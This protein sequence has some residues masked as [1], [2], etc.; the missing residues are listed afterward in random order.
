MRNTFDQCGSTKV[1]S[2]LWDHGKAPDGSHPSE[3][4]VRA[5]LDVYKFAPWKPHGDG[6]CGEGG[7][8]GPGEPEGEPTDEPAPAP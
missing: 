4:V 2:I 7:G 1:K 8:R 3:L 6:T 5:T